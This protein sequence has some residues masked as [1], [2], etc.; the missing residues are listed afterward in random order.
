[1]ANGFNKEEIVM[2]DEM[3]AGF[4]DAL[5]VSKLAT[6]YQTDQTTME[7]TNDVIW[8]PQPYIMTS[9]DGLDQSANF[10]DV[11]Q[12]AVPASINTFKSSNWTLTANELR[13]ALQ[14][15]RIRDGAKQR[16]SSDINISA[17]LVASKD[18]K[19]VV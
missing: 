18:R 9:F 10:G 16:L 2:F 3:L 19:S 14:E 15:G 7:R 4:D 8:R 1:M 17:N 13:D 12:L 5:V 6:V 11:V